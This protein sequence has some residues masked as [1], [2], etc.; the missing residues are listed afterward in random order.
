MKIDI[1]LNQ[2]F[3]GTIKVNYPPL[4]ILNTNEFREDIES[5]LPLLRNKNWKCKI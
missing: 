3:Y 2:R 5:R 1:F 4:F